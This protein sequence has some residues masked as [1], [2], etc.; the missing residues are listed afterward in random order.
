MVLGF[1]E[2]ASCAVTQELPRILRN[3]K[4]HYRVHKSPP[5]VPILRSIQSIPLHPISL[6]SI[7]ILYT[8]LYLGLPSDLF[9]FS[10]KYHTCIPFLPMRVICP[11]HLILDTIILIILGE[12]YK[13]WSSSLC[14]FL[15]PLV[16][17]SLFCPNINVSENVS[18]YFCRYLLFVWLSNKHQRSKLSSYKIGPAWFSN[19]SCHFSCHAV[20][21]L[22]Y[23]R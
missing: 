15:K 17:S 7:L 3:P 16:T 8:H 14:S 12:E 6:R 2:A 10:H 4:V 18:L 5:Q 9:W 13:F 20:P 1:W 21:S 22:R 23:S 11:V 19:I